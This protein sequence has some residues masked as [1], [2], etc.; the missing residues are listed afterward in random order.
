M[1]IR[2]LKHIRLLLTVALV[3]VVGMLHAQTS[4]SQF[5]RLFKK[6][7]AQRYTKQGLQWGDSMLTMARQQRNRKAEVMAMII[8]M[9]YYY[10][11]KDDKKFDKW[12]ATMQQT[13]LNIICRTTTITR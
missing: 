5:N 2:L 11:Q 6:A 8:P 1:S 3:A 4:N 10:Q 7:F 9:H 12:V 13:A